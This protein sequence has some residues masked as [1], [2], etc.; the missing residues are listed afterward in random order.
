MASPH[1]AALIEDR[2]NRLKMAA[3]SDRGYGTQIITYTGYGSTGSG[4]SS[5]C[6]LPAAIT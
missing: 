1:A 4:V 3:L 2:W 6:T 5:A